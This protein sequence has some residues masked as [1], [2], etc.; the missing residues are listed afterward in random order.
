MD[1]GYDNTILEISGRTYKSNVHLVGMHLRDARNILTFLQSAGSIGRPDLLA[2][3]AILLSAAGLESNLS[4]YSTLALAI[5]DAKPIYKQPELEFL[6]A[7]QMEYTKEA[8]LRPS[9]QKQA[10]DERL[11]LVPALL[12]RSFGRKFELEVGERGIER[13]SNMIERRDAIIHP[14]WDRY[15]VVGPT[16]AVDALYGVLEYVDSVRMQ[17]FPYMIGYIVMMSAYG[18]V[19]AAASADPVPLRFRELMGQKELVEGLCSNWVDA[20]MMF[21]VAN[22]HRTEGDSEGSMLTRA[23]LVS[24]Y[25]MVSAELSCIGRLAQIADAAALTEYDVNYLNEQAPKISGEGIAV[26]EPIKQKF[27]DRATL[28][29]TIISKNLCPNVFTFDRGATWFQNM[30]KKYFNMRNGVMHSKF[31]ECLPRVSKAELRE[32]FESVRAYFGHIATADGMLACYRMLLDSSPLRS[33]A[34]SADV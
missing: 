34:P 2:K 31:G 15:P 25:A 8:E 33:L 5:Q 32:A 10:L 24:L 7:V 17:F 9:K 14:G 3:A 27:E 18:S 20:H 12:G 6:K 1:Q 21:D 26:M 13:L 22:M 29:P 19:V 23:A 4:Y 11:R 30:F 16:D 28:V